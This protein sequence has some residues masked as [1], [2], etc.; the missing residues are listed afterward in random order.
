MKKSDN[1]SKFY[2]LRELHPTFTFKDYEIAASNDGLEIVFSFNISD[3]YYFTPSIRIPNVDCSNVDMSLIDTLA[4][5]IGMIEMVS[6]WKLTC[7][8]NIVIKPKKLSDDAI[9]WW[10]RLYFNGLGEF[11]YLNNI[12][13]PHDKF[14]TI[15]CEGDQE[16]KQ[17]DIALKNI[18]L[19]PIG[20]GKDSVVTLSRLRDGGFDVKPLI[21]NPRG[22]TIECIEAAGYKMSEVLIV[23]RKLDP[24]MIK[25][26][27]EGFLNGHTPFSALLAFVTLLASAVTGRRNIA[28]SNENSANESTVR[29]SEVNHQYSKSYQFESDFRDYVARYISVNFNYFSFLR[30]LSELRIASMFAE[31]KE[32]YPVFKS[33]NAGSK[34]DVWCCD[35]P[36]CLF[37]YIILSP[38]ISQIEMIKIFG[39]DLFNKHSMLA[40]LDELTGISEVKPFECVGTVNEVKAALYMIIQNYNGKAL[41]L[42]HF[43]NSVAFD[44]SLSNVFDNV[45]NEFDKHNF[46]NEE[47]IKLLK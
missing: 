28:L 33:C 37:A 15:K 40:Y 32:F 11:F 24:L 4:F 9:R 41:L 27:G 29:N 1:A 10:K 5:H 16:L 2:N 8:P 21:M 47:Q 23:E 19:V 22:A 13:I 42:E 17:F 3:N 12:E 26:N 14:V 44:N 38:F 6:Y 25:L 35:C 46:L 7:S 18:Y 36:K 39:E 20:G 45:M 43:K 31:Y 34:T 30:P